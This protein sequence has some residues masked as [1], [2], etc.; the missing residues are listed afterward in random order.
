MASGAFIS[1]SNISLPSFQ[2]TRTLGCHLA[3]LSDSEQSRI[4]CSCK[5]TSAIS[6]SLFLRDRIEIGLSFPSAL[7]GS[8]L[9]SW[10]A[11]RSG[12]CRSAAARRWS[13]AL[14]RIDQRRP[15]DRGADQ[16]ADLAGFVCSVPLQEPHDGGLP[17]TAG[18]RN[19]LGALA[20]VHEAR[21][22]SDEGFVGLDF[23]CPCGCSQ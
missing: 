15:R 7:P 5:F 13:G 10:R 11:R 23:G 4:T 19:L 14:A 1:C 9:T 18:A 20:L 17:N 12:P 22:A 8:A 21:F 3:S 6:A 16:R 2:N